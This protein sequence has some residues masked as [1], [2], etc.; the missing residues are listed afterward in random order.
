M[1]LTT[2]TDKLITVQRDDAQ[3]ALIRSLMARLVLSRETVAMLQ[4]QLSEP[5]TTDLVNLLEQFSREAEADEQYRQAK[6]EY[7][8]LRRQ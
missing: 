7:F 2:F 6:S 4:K 3:V 8:R 1:D 5:N